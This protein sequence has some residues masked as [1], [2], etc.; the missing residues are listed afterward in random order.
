MD[1][2]NYLKSFKQTGRDYCKLQRS[3]R[4]AAFKDRV[5]TEYI[6]TPFKHDWVLLTQMHDLRT[7][8]LAY[9]PSRSN[10]L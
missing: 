4:Q 3:F 8:T 9:A 6:K 2:L 7:W 1:K 5:S 10:N